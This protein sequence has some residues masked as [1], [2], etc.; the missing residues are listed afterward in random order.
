[1]NYSRKPDTDMYF[2]PLITNCHIR[3]TTA[4]TTFREKHSDICYS[5]P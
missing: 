5:V 3:K 1:M 4:L 2:S